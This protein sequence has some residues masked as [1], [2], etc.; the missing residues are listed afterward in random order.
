MNNQTIPILIFQLAAFIGAL[1]QL[2]YKKGS[3]KK[4]K[5]KSFLFIN[6][7][8]L[9]GMFLY[10]AVIGLF[11]LAYSLGG[12][13]SIL[14]P[15]YAAT[16]IWALILAGIYYKEKITVNKIAGVICVIGGIYLVTL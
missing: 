4:N 7:Y 14:Y 5:Y 10:F 3:T 9:L 11:I 8:I 12:S 6:I 2:L 16:F 1:G 15:S 13:L